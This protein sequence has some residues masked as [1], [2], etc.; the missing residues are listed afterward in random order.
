MARLLG[1]DAVDRLYLQQR[2]VLLV[3]ARR[4]HLAVDLV[5]A[6]QLEAADL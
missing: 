6:A 5:A 2:V 1:I 3:V 4:A